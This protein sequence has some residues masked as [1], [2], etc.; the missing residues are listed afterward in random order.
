MAGPKRPTRAILSLLALTIVALGAAAYFVNV[1]VLWVV[2]GVVGA[3]LGLLLLAS[4]ARR[5]QPVV[6]ETAEPPAE[7]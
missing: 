6:N 3:L 5:A 4:R 1:P 2:A 7:P